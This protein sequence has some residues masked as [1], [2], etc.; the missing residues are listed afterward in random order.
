VLNEA[1]QI[2][3]IVE[4]LE[5]IAFDEWD[6]FMRHALERHPHVV[7]PLL[8]AIAEHHPDDGWRF[9]AI[10]LLGHR[11][12]ADVAR[13]LLGRETGPETAALLRE[14]LAGAQR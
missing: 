3:D 12:S 1:A 11:L 7:A 2:Q 14:H 8:V 10:Q 4:A 13:Q 5:P 6:A 9:N